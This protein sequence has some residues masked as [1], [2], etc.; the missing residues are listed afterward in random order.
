[1]GNLLPYGFAGFVAGMAS[2][3]VTTLANVTQSDTDISLS[4]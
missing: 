4:M 3:S 2:Y 1:M